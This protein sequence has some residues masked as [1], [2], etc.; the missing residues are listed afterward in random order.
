MRL[1]LILPLMLSGI[2]LAQPAVAQDC[3]AA[4]SAQA[5]AEVLAEVNRLR[6]SAG[7][8]GLRANRALA[9][10]A[11]GHACDNAGRNS[12]SHSGSDGSDL[13]RRLDRGGYNYREAAENTGLGRFTAAAMVDYWNRSPAHRTNMLNPGVT[14]AGLGLAKADNGRNAW[15]L[16]LGRR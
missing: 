16:V 5:E 12:Y 15:V 8:S 3:T 2:V 7:L 11:Q 4:H 14:E 6:A 10:V 1:A 9:S 13:G